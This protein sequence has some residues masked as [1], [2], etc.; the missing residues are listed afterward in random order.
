MLQAVSEFWN[1]TAL[2]DHLSNVWTKV[3]LRY[4][5]EPTIAGYDLLNEP[6]IYSSVIPNLN[7]S[8]LESFYVK[9]IESIRAVDPN[10]VIFLE[11]ANMQ[12]GNFPIKDNIVWSPHFYP[13]SFANRYDPQNITVL[14]ADLEAKY[15]KFVLEMGSPMWVGEFAAFMQD[16]SSVRWLRDA[17]T[18]FGE[19][20]V[21]WAW[22]AYSRTRGSLSFTNLMKALNLSTTGNASTN[23]SRPMRVQA[24]ESLSSTRLTSDQPSLVPPS[25]VS[26]AV[27]LSLALLAACLIVSSPTLRGRSVIQQQ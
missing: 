2:Q 1:S 3:A 5:K 7:A 23:A 26:N 13:L 11:P 4:A 24:Q 19:Y 18:L 10:H 15:Q 6:S 17:V 27:L 12:S 22:W 25:H 20:H 21:G 9:V 16:A 14:R 8:H